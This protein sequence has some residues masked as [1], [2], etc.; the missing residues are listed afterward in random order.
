MISSCDSNRM[1]MRWTVLW[2]IPVIS[3]IPSHVAFLL[4][5]R[6]LHKM[7]ILLGSC[8]FWS[9]WTLFIFHVILTLQN[10]GNP[11]A[12]S[13]N[14][15]H[16]FSDNSVQLIVNFREL[17]LRQNQK[18]DDVNV[19]SRERSFSGRCFHCYWFQISQAHVRINQKHL[20]SNIRHFLSRGVSSLC[21]LRFNL[22]AN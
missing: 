4:F 7:Q 17:L 1:K 8:T 6:D 20:H 2:E 22:N 21:H 19:V 9:S 3:S 12:H 11:F 5:H 18:L 15:W 13:L 10:F 16:W 14:R